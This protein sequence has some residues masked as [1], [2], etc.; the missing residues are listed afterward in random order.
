MRP[1]PV[2]EEIE[3]DPKEYIFSST[4]LRGVINWGNRYFV[5]ISGYNFNELIGKPH[6]ILRHPDMPRVAFKLMWETIQK[7]DEFVAVV[8]N[9]A[10]S[11]KYYWVV[12]RIVPIRDEKTNEITGYT[13]YRRA[14]CKKIQEAVTPLYAELLRIEKEHHNNMFESEQYLKDLLAKEG[15]TYDEFIKDLIEKN[16]TSANFFGRVKKVF[17]FGGK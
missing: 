9:M 7:G 13:A 17:S 16:E 8:K 11:G 10:K 1:T 12:A 3:L 5:Q 14:A 4:D 6:N 2:N 15:V